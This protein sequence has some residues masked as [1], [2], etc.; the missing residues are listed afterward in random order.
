MKQ[1]KLFCWRRFLASVASYDPNLPKHTEGKHFC[2]MLAIS[3]FA[4]G[5][6]TRQHGTL[7]PAGSQVLVK[8]ED[9]VD[10]WKSK[11]LKTVL[12]A[13]KNRAR[14]LIFHCQQP[15]WSLHFSFF[16][17]FMEV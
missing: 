14:A 16:P 5:L 15:T 3:L 17:N 2:A 10:T 4:T 13:S 6:R 7:G 11:Q 8:W 9:R 12:E 1:H